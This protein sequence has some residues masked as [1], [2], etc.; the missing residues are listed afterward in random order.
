MTSPRRRWDQQEYFRGVPTTPYDLIKEVAIALV[1][2]LVVVLALAAVLSS[3]DVPPLTLQSWAR[4]APLDFVKTAT[5][6]LQ[7]ATLS[8][9]YGPPYN[10]G[11]GSLQ[12]LGPLA[13]ELWAGVHQPVDAAVT[14][15]L[16]PLRVASVGVPGLGAALNRF[17]KA[18]VPQQ[19]AW[20]VSYTRALGHAQLIN[21]QPV[22]P[23]AAYGPLETMMRALLT[24]ARSGGLD[25][26]LVRSGH[27]Y[28]TD[29]TRALLFLGDGG[30]LAA[31]AAQQHLLGT[32]WGVMNE[33]GR[34][35]G[36]AWLWLYTL[37]YQI[38]P[39][40]TAQNADLLVIL[41]MGFLTTLL[42]LT[43]FIPGLRDIP[44]WIP[45]YRLI[46]REHYR[47]VRESTLPRGGSD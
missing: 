3:P 31:V 35:P 4:T 24:Q 22:V 23:H 2:M 39:Y 46:W 11:T 30:Y 25:A 28:Q 7:G 9:S 36:Q 10:R 17:E 26:L 15:V 41:T 29:Y 40:N 14:D 13:P 34:Y 44:R 6:E 19:D 45:L 5:A 33:T 18:S 37:W 20:L 27:F 43:P 21:A 8:S 1:V 16:A 32:Q 38:P 47:F 42:L 12:T